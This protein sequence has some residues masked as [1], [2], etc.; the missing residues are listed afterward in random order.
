MAP[1][2][3]RMDLIRK[4]KNVFTAFDSITG[5]VTFFS[6]VQKEIY[7]RSFLQMEFQFWLLIDIPMEL[8][9]TGIDFA[10]PF[11]TSETA[12]LAFR[13]ASFLMEAFKCACTFL[14]LNFSPFK[15]LRTHALTVFAYSFCSFTHILCFRLEGRFS[16]TMI[17]LVPMVSPP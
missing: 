2:N 8:R 15:T 10:N 11:L 7:Q 1:R 14:E 6:L 9:K 12:F 5:I 17:V 3:S 13:I 16:F 4:G